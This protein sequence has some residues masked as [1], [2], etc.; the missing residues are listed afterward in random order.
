MDGCFISGWTSLFFCSHI[1]HNNIAIQFHFYLNTIDIKSGA[2]HKE[3][4][5]WNFIPANIFSVTI[6]VNVKVSEAALEEEILCL[7]GSQFKVELESKTIFP[8]SQLKEFKEQIL[9]KY[10]C[11]HCDYTSDK[12]SNLKRHISLNHN[13]LACL[14]VAGATKSFEYGERSQRK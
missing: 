11:E 1:V 8:N 2:I 13:E 7:S 10:I 6:S 12:I 5:G 4:S 3:F 9:L 14:I